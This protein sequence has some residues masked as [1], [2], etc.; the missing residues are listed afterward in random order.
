MQVFWWVFL[1]V[2][3]GALAY[4]VIQGLREGKW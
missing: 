3:L 4:L 1:L 2:T